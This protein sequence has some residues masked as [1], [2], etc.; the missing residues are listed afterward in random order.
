MP[1][2][3][4]ASSARGCQ[5]LTEGADRTISRGTDLVTE[6]GRNSFDIV[7]ATGSWPQPT[8]NGPSR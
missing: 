2:T 3:D 6:L 8:T 5:V 1:M 4:R 7:L